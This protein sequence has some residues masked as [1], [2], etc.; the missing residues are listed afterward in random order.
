MPTNSAAWNSFP[1]RKH[2]VEVELT[3]GILPPADLDELL[4][5]GDFGR[6]LDA[7]DVTCACGR[8]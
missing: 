5:I 4:D 7:P 6:H 8:G 3:F 2:G 1:E